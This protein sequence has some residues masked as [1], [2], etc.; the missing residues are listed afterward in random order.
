MADQ[1]GSRSS[2]A[3]V[4]EMPDELRLEGT[5]RIAYRLI[6]SLIKVVAKL[7]FRLEVHGQ[8]NLPAT[9]GFILAPG[10]HRSILDTP[11]VSGAG[12]RLWRYMGAES[13]F[14]I[15]VLGWFLRVMGG[16]PVERAQS[17]RAALRASEQVLANGE[18]LV[19]FPEG[20][21]QS[22]PVI[23]SL[24]EGAAYLAGRAQV[25]IVPVGMGGT[26]RA[27]PKGR[28]LPR[29][30]KLVL[31][32]GEPIDPPQGTDGRR[33]SRSQVRAV[34]EQLHQALQELFDEAQIRAGV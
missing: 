12:P 2:P 18:P 28:Y 25:P 22:G 9:G 33:A 29:P 21:R 7:A 5:A 27:L 17:D 34:S 19:V 16:F 15:P 32:V 4:G 1:N 23:G 13:Y 24:K 26:E 6:R 31:V 14:R 3:P 8:Q 30:R 10:A 11:I 20:T